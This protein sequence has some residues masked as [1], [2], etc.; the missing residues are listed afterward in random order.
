MNYELSKTS[1]W[2]PIVFILDLAFDGSIT[3]VR[4]T[5]FLNDFDALGGDETTGV[6]VSDIV[7]NSFSNISSINVNTGGTSF[8]TSSSSTFLED[9]TV[10]DNNIFTISSLSP[11]L[12]NLSTSGVL[13]ETINLSQ[14]GTY[15]GLAVDNTDTISVPESS[16][17]WGIGMFGLLGI[18]ALKRSKK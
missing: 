15:V 13:L 17:L 18:F 5:S 12:W 3:N 10:I 8:V 16:H 2:F 14:T 4:S 9:L 11:Q 6:F 1:Y 7:N